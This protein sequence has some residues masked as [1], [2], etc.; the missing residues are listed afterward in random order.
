ME[1]KKEVGGQLQR[2]LKQRH[3][4]MIAIG[5]SIGTALFL[6]TGY[7][8]NNAGPGGLVVAYCIVAVMVFFII[9]SLGEMATY[10]PCAGSFQTY[11]SLYVSPSFGFAIGW[12]YWFS[13]AVTVGIEVVAASIVMAF[14]F[15]NV[16]GWI[17]SLA[18]CIIVVG[19]NLLSAKAYGEA[20]FWFASIKVVAVVSFL[21]TCIG[22]MTGVVGGDAI[23][24]TN[25]THSV[26]GLFPKGFGAA[27]AVSFTAVFCFLGTEIVGIAAGEGEN[28][29]VTIPKAVRTVFVRIAIFYLGATFMIAA[30]IPWME[31]TVH[32]S[33]FTVVFTKIGIGAAATLMNFVVLTSTLSCANAGLYASSRMVFS[34][35]KEGKAPAVFAKVSSRGVPVPALLLTAMM[36]GGAFLS[37]F[38]SPDKVYVLLVS[39]SSIAVLFAWIGICASHYKF[40][41]W[42][43]AKG[44][45]LSELKFK[46]PFFPIGPM[47][48]GAL[49]IIVIIAQF[50]DKTTF[51][52]A[53]LGV[54]IFI[55]L[56]VWG[57]V[58]EKKGT[59]YVPTEE[60]IRAQSAQEKSNS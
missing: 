50:F 26:G 11:S 49:C 31:G 30:T 57:K 46:A 2:T 9:M 24:F 21:I 55:I 39:A 6:S 29:E 33:P 28:P 58:K 32:V 34:M 13:W 51:I 5:G 10:L 14:W 25:F 1:D 36:G 16:P 8:L 22:M 43:K 44:H 19:L 53:A 54:P 59:L 35:A 17:W 23:G 41:L 52:T 40:R 3:L 27:I 47:I 37:K 45:D 38:I 7:A 12:T 18:F 56:W 4:T 60:S 15:P 20:E 48:A 42:F